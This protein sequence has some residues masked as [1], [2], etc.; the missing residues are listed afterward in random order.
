MFMEE[1]KE[2]YIDFSCPECGNKL[3][4]KKTRAGGE[5]APNVGN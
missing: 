1:K 4:A 2:L 3:R 5:T